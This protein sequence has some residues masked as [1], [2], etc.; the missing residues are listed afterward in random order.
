[1]RVRKIV[2]IL[3][4]ILVSVLFYNYYH[5]HHK[6]T[7]GTNDNSEIVKR[8]N[9]RQKTVKKQNN[10]EDEARDTLESNK[11]VS[12][13]NY[14]KVKEQIQIPINYL[15]NV[16]SQADIKVTY[17]NRLSITSQVV[18]ES[19]KTMLLAGYHF[20]IDTLKVYESDATNVYQFTINLVTDYNDKLSLVGNYAIGTNQFEFVSLHGTPV[21]VMF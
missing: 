16:K 2:A 14:E 20:K 18:A 6:V 12:Q 7:K 10:I 11:K 1:M 3:V 13:D 17:D 4:I 9:K 19:I 8:I 21:N 15:V 5:H